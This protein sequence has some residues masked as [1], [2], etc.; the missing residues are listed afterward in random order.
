[1]ASVPAWLRI[2]R[3]P[4]LGFGPTLPFIVGAI[5]DPIGAAPDSPA[6]GR[7]E[8]FELLRVMDEKAPAA[9]GINIQWCQTVDAHVATYVARRGLSWYGSK[10]EDVTGRDV[11]G[12]RLWA[13]YGDKI[14]S[15]RYSKDKDGEWHCY[16]EG[17]LNTIR[18]L[19]DE[20]A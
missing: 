8:L 9:C 4:A 12:K 11:L 13:R 20:D 15:G 6:A 1:M 16:T 17:E 14:A 18:T 5:R 2:I 10:F 19:L 3:N 7:Q